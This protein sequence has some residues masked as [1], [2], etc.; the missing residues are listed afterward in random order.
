MNNKYIAIMCL[1]SLSINVLSSCAPIETKNNAEIPVNNE[2][3]SINTK[4]VINEDTPYYSITNAYI[5]HYKNHYME[6]D[7]KI[8]KIE[9][10]NLASDLLFDNI[11]DEILTNA[12]KLIDK[13]VM[14]A[15]ETYNMYLKSARENILFDK[16]NKLKNL[17]VKYQNLLGKKEADLVNKILEDIKN[18]ATS[19]EIA[20]YGFASSDDPI[21]I[22]P[23]LHNKNI[24]I[25]DNTK[26]TTTS[27]QNEIIDKQETYD[28]NK[29]IK[30]KKAT[31]S[32]STKEQSKKDFNIKSTASQISITKASTSNATMKKPTLLTE[33][34]SKASISN[35][36]TEK[37]T[38]KGFYNELEEISKIKVPDAKSLTEGYTP[39]HIYCDFDVKCLD[40]DYI[41]IFI[42]L[43]ESRTVT[44]SKLMYYNIDLHNHKILKIND[45]LG[46][47][48]KEICINSINSQINN[49]NSDKKSTL[50]KDYNIEK[51]IDNNI[52]FFINNNHVPVVVFD[53]YAI[54]SGAGGYPEFQI[55]NKE[56]S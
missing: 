23:A 47:N 43:Y 1:I 45:I 4:I 14:K 36:T 26:E 15:N 20:V 29:K 28:D 30:A 21:I 56:N 42:E 50:L 11:N 39:T 52:T 33:N 3:N 51:F 46:D 2:E 25:I 16:E 32:I 6:L 10:S 53:K 9:Y 27:M 24:I 13:S 55:I 48:Y 41:S 38:I 37:L 35:T 31:D 17:V 49:W 8:P 54:T 5:E 18:E 12:T 7:I 44:S 19:S 34:I 40:E 22:D